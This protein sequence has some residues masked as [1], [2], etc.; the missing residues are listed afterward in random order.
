MGSFSSIRS[1]F[2]LFCVVYI[3]DEMTHAAKQ[4][5][6]DK[7]FVS[8]GSYHCLKHSLYRIHVRFGK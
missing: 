1:N 8:G 3:S 6:G 7:K 4:S 5:V 2:L